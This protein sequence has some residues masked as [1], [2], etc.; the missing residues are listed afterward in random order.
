[1]AGRSQH[2]IQIMATQTHFNLNAA[3][4]N[5]RNELAVQSQ[6]TPDARRELEKHLADSIT[7]L[8]GRGLS[9]DESFWLAQRRIGRPEKIAEEFEKTDPGKMWQERAFWMAIALA[10]SYLFMTWK[11]LLATWLN[12][13][14]WVEVFYLVPI[15][16]LACAVIMIRRGTVPVQK[17]YSCWP[18]SLG[19]LVVLLTTIL[20]AYFRGRSLP[21]D[22]LIAIG[23]NIGMVTSWFANATW[24]VVMVLT[25]LLAQ[26]W[27]RKTRKRA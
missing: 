24:P 19:L 26:K 21:S 1:M 23:Y 9:E 20:V 25:V 5:W 4:E 14:A 7:D 16:V 22:D 10:G 17:N 27:N 2:L 6:L 11:D 18:L 13:S 15:F 8:H 12:Q 3:I